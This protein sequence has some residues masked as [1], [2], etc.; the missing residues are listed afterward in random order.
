[1]S[2]TKRQALYERFRRGLAL[3]PDRPAL[4]IGAESYTYRD[5]TSRLSPGPAPSAPPRSSA[6][7]RARA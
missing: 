4:R 3:S 2:D 1:M 5:C 6:S 7:S